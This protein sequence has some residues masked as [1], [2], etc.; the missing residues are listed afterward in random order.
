MP[1]SGDPGRFPFLPSSPVIS[2]AAG[3]HQRGSSGNATR[4]SEV[5]GGNRNFTR[6]RSTDVHYMAR[7]GAEIQH[8]PE[9]YPRDFRS[10]HRQI[11]G[12]QSGWSLGPPVGLG[13]FLGAVNTRHQRKQF[14]GRHTAVAGPAILDWLP[15]GEA[16]R[17][18]VGD[19]E[20]K[21]EGF[22]NI[23]ALFAVANSVE[24][25]SAMGPS[26][27]FHDAKL[28]GALIGKYWPSK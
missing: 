14:R 3:S 15:F 4:C 5:L 13:L 27:S 9:S 24:V 7:L 28:R 18:P 23:E 19:F 26:R 17:W 22:G 8:T 11:C 20:E 16:G 10:T 2:V 1:L 21:A 6:V 25:A 12:R